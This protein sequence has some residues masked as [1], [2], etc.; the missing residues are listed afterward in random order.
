MAPVDPKL[1]YF[2]AYGHGTKAVKTRPSMKTLGHGNGTK[3][4]KNFAPLYKQICLA[5]VHLELFFL[6][7]LLSI[8]KENRLL[9]CN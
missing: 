9:K 7:L 2:T 3:V 4:Y 8:F 5:V 6:S 1:T